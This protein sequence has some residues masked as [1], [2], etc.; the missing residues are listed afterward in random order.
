MKKFIPLTI[1]LSLILLITIAIN[2]LSMDTRDNSTDSFD[3]ENSVKKIDKKNTDEY[4]VN[5]VEVDFDLPDFILPDL[6][7]K[8]KY[9]SKKDFMGKYTIV[10]F[11]ASWCSTC[12]MEHEEL[13]IMQ[14]QGVADLYG[15]AWRDINENT[16]KYL[17]KNG[18][19]FLRVGAD[20]KALFSEIAKIEAVPETWLVNPQGKVVL[21]LKGNLL[22]FSIDEIRKYIDLH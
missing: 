4:E 15:I 9:L 8:N 12:I 5:F 18:N 2:N 16:I 14:S 21:R 19:P 6:F 17:Q 11:F 3:Q 13:L 1:L 7:E 10:N 22:N 20:N